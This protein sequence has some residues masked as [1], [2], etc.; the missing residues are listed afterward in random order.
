MNIYDLNRKYQSFG[1]TMIELLVVITILVAA[2]LIGFQAVPYAI[3][4][5]KIGEAIAN[6]KLISEAA[7]LYSTDM[8]FY[9]PDVDRGCDPGF[10]EKLPHTV[11][12]PSWACNTKT[13]IPDYHPSDWQSRLDEFWLGPYIRDWN[14]LTPW[15]G[16]YDYNYWP[17]GA[18]RYGECIAP[19][20]YIGVQRDYSNNNPIP[21]HAEQ[22][23]LDDGVDKD[24]VL[25]GE[26]QLLVLKLQSSSPVCTP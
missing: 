4:K 22:R 25:N 26:A 8:G 1:F 3:D 23:M 16:K 14:K 7:D 5:G 13:Y 9:P 10:L 19:G 12:S 2:T 21:S 15:G 24:L 6:A 17:D 20:V 18:V 11:E